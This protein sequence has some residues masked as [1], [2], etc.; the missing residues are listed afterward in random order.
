MAQVKTSMVKRLDATTYSKIA[1]GAGVDLS[2]V[3]HIM[4]GNRMPSIPVARRIAKHL[5][6]SL[7]QFVGH[8]DTIRETVAA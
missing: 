2:Y 7:D 1:A 8:L 3:S 4:A 6:V 5:G